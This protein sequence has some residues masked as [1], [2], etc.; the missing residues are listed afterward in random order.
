MLRTLH[1]ADTHTK[2]YKSVSTS[3]SRGSLCCSSPRLCSASQASCYPKF[4]CSDLLQSFITLDVSLLQSWE[5]WEIRQ[6]GNLQQRINPLWPKQF[7]RKQ[8][9]SN[10]LMQDREYNVKSTSEAILSCSA[11]TLVRR[12]F[13]G[14]LVA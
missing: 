1:K 13:L 2:K 5:K 9:R 4:S 11:H 14:A 10:F 8:Q 6:I 3:E 12:G 7:E